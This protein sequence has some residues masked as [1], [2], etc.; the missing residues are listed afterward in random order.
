MKLKC[1]LGF[2][3]FEPVYQYYEVLNKTLAVRSVICV[4]CNAPMRL[5]TLSYHWG[6]E[7]PTVEEIIIAL[8]QFPPETEIGNIYNKLI[9]SSN[10]T[11]Q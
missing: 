8:S 2:H 7:E 6:W 3:K 10:P 4:H 1:A 5:S 9:S 11:L